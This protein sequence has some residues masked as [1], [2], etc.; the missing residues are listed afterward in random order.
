VSA[1]ALTAGGLTARPAWATG[2]RRLRHPATVLTTVG[3]SVFALL[4][5]VLVIIGTGQVVL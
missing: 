4:A 3:L 1:L 5:V 2:D